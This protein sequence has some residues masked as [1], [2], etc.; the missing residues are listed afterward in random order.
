[1][2]TT[3]ITTATPSTA[4]TTTTPTCVRTTAGMTVP[5][6]FITAT[7]TPI[8]TRTVAT[9]SNPSSRDNSHRVDEP[10]RQVLVCVD[11]AV[12]QERPVRPAE[13]DLL[14]ICRDDDDLFL[15]HAR[16]LHDLPV[17]RGDEAL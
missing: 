8:T 17:G 1:M 12:A 5:A 15:L 10:L 13:L 2:T 4:P 14:Q 6:T 9:G 11:P 7:R 3:M 16:P